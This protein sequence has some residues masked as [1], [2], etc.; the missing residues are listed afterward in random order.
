MGLRPEQFNIE[1]LLRY[2]RNHLVREEIIDE[3]KDLTIDELNKLGI[4][5]NDYLKYLKMMIKRHYNLALTGYGM[6]EIKKDNINPK[7]ELTNMGYYY[8]DYIKKY[9]LQYIL[10]LRNIKWSEYDTQEKLM[11]RILDSNP[12]EEDSLG[13]SISSNIYDEDGKLVV[14]ES[15]IDK[16]SALEKNFI[17]EDKDI[18]VKIALK[19]LLTQRDVKYLND[20]KY[21]WLL[22]KALQ[23]N[24]MVN[25]AL[26]TDCSYIDKNSFY[27]YNYLI[28]YGLN[29]LYSI[30]DIN[31]DKNFNYDNKL[32]KLENLEKAYNY[33]M[34][35]RED[36]P[37]DFESNSN[38]L[39][40]DGELK[41]GV[42]YTLDYLKLYGLRK[43]FKL[44]NLDDS[45]LDKLFNNEYTYSI[46]QD[47]EEKILFSN[48]KKSE[49]TD[50]NLASLKRLINTLRATLNYHLL[51]RN[52]SIGE[53]YYFNKSENAYSGYSHLDVGTVIDTETS[54][55][56]IGVIINN[57]D[58]YKTNDDILGKLYFNFDLKKV[59][60]F[61][62]GTHGGR[63][64]YTVFYD[65]NCL[66][67]KKDDQSYEDAYKT[68]E[69]FMRNTNKQLI[70]ENNI[71]TAPI[72]FD[73]L[74][75]EIFMLNG[76][77]YNN[78]TENIEYDLDNSKV[79]FTDEKFNSSELGFIYNN[80]D[81]TYLTNLTKNYSTGFIDGY[82][83]DNNV[84]SNGY[85]TFGEEYFKGF[86]KELYTNIITLNS[87]MKL[88]K[89]CSNFILVIMP[90]EDDNKIIGDINILSIT[91][92]G[93]VI[94]KNTGLSKCKFRWM[95]IC[96]DYIVNRKIT[97]KIYKE[98][99]TLNFT[100][101]E[102]SN[103]V[104]FYNIYSTYYDEFITSN[105]NGSF[106]TF[107]ESSK[108]SF[109][110]YFDYEKYD[111]NKNIEKPV[112]ENTYLIGY[113]ELKI[114]NTKQYLEFT[115][116]K[117]SNVNGKFD[118][119]EKALPSGNM[120]L[121]Y[122][123]KFNSTT[124]NGIDGNGYCLMLV[125][126]QDSFDNYKLVKYDSESKFYK[127]DGTGDMIIG[128]SDSNYSIA[129]GTYFHSSI[130]TLVCG[131]TSLYI[132]GNGKIG[133]IVTDSGDYYGI[134]NNNGKQ[135]AILMENITDNNDT[136]KLCKVFIK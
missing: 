12:N 93:K 38:R 46:K 29:V 57:I 62:S 124:L 94:I 102:N 106:I 67:V 83:F 28:E 110:N 33:I 87:K 100:M 14:E 23:T 98:E 73:N 4:K 3:L 78:D 109:Y 72:P 76:V 65:F 99:K 104:L 5:F 42:Y 135:V 58:D 41:L 121:N 43:L 108:S 71:A 75:N 131:I 1:Q 68:I 82:D 61:N 64:N 89:D 88:N 118:R 126:N 85:I 7:D 86:S 36:S 130:P 20:T 17:Y 31:N 35:E 116:G 47:I 90:L 122:S 125:T 24:A 103:N 11:K 128:I 48:P 95:I 136:I 91:D 6:P 111:I 25:Y 127:T 27:N 49:Y 74:E 134:I 123:G 113:M 63:F 107:N 79:K 39:N 92:D 112:K 84:Y 96:N 69:R 101:I 70:S 16:L 9:P 30:Y 18:I 119:N 115:N 21:D 45:N 37:S 22:D 77:A 117:L 66:A 51:T 114:P 40:D 80:E 15:K 26:T 56:P 55:A 53:E 13:V 50:L 54:F 19:D 105:I 133:D 44:R 8:E 129:S 81:T 132:K 120:I 60:I 52:Y 59:K 34:T 32:S 2:F 10:N 97:N